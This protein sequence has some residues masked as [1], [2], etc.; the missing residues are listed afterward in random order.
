MSEVTAPAMMVMGAIMGGVSLVMTVLGVI[1]RR[2]VK[3]AIGVGLGLSGLL[4]AYFGFSALGVLKLMGSGG[5]PRMAVAGCAPIVSCA[6]FVWLFTWLL[7]A[8]RSTPGA[9]QMQAAYQAQYA[10]YV[11]QQQAYYQQNAYGQG[12]YNAPPAAAAPGAAAS[13]WQWPAQPQ[14]QPMQ[15]PGPMSQQGLAPPPPPPGAPPEA[16]ASTPP[17]EGGPDGQGPQG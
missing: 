9:E 14:Q 1:V 11:A 3:R 16:S 6:L 17:S 13:G 8:R 15:A 2:G 5:D 7:G 4:A 10:Q 12:A